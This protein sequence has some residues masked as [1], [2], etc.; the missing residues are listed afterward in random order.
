MYKK[1][2]YIDDVSVSE[3]EIW[4]YKAFPYNTNGKYL[5]SDLNEISIKI[6]NATVYG[7]SLDQSE[8]DP[9]S[10][11]TYLDT[12]D[13]ANFTPAYMNFVD[14]VFEYGSWT[15]ENGAWFMDV[16]PCLLKSSGEIDCYLDPNDYTKDI[17]GNSVTITDGNYDGSVM[18]EIP[19]VYYKVVNIDDDI[20]EFYFSNKKVDDDYVCWSHIDCQGNTIPY[21]YISAYDASLTNNKLKSISGLAHST[22]STDYSTST[23]YINNDIT[24]PIWHIETYSDRILM[25]YLIMLIGR[26]TNT[27][28]TFGNGYTG[29][30][31]TDYKIAG[32]YNT[33]GLFYGVNNNNESVKLFG[34]ENLWG[35]HYYKVA[36]VYLDENKLHVKMTYD[37]TDGSSQN[38]YSSTGDGYIC[39][40]NEHTVGFGGVFI[41]KM[42]F[43]NY[44]FYPVIGDGTATTY[45]CD[46]Y[47]RGNG[48][49]YCY[50]G[51]N[52]NGGSNNGTFSQCYYYGY[53]CNCY[54]G[55]R[56]SCRPLL[57]TF[58]N[59]PSV[60]V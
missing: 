60:A 20:T 50:G 25:T 19:L 35:N 59:H 5:N 58:D 57:S 39:I 40:E 1:N 46:A 32:T 42:H 51:L 52:N 17:D 24:N 29:N 2:P 31:V 49:H 14:D 10:M 33:K 36:G 56:I 22:S 38:G 26:N 9:A 47:K 3:G 12:C 54:S 55:A 23:L 13:N 37:T 27:Q 21:C 4:Y 41:T 30:S 16:K 18:V 34:I 6:T 28:E 44:G 45:F 11:I 8:S 43:S 7:F 15:V 53:A 48:A